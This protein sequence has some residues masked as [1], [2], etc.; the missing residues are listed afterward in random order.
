LRYLGEETVS[1]VFGSLEGIC[2][3]KLSDD[4]ILII[5]D[6]SIKLVSKE[7]EKRCPTLEKLQ[8]LI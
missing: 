8:Q 4:D 2:L 3:D 1:R 5:K 7:E 6:G